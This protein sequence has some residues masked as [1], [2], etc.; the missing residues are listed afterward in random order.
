M[1]PPQHDLSV[2]FD[3]REQPDFPI[4]RRI[5]I[6]HGLYGKARPPMNDWQRR[7]FVAQPFDVR[8]SHSWIGLDPK[9]D[10]KTHPE[11]FAEVDGKRKASKPAYANPEVIQIAIDHALKFFKEHPEAQMISLSPPDGLGFDT[12]ELAKKQAKVVETF[13]AHGTIFGRQKDGTLVSLASENVFHFVNEVAKAV[14]R[15]Y[16]GK[17]VGILAYSAYA[18]PP[19]FDIEPNVYVELTR[20][21]RRTP[22]S[23]VEQIVAFSKKAKN[24]GIYEYYD[25]EQW[26]WERPGRAQRLRPQLPA[27]QLQVL[28]PIQHARP[29]W[30]D[31]QQLRPYGVGYHVLAS[32]LWDATQDVGS[33]RTGVL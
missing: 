19:S 14:Q 32:L 27:R 21:Y 23:S 17:M 25:V 7:N 15:E 16:P 20:G 8:T 24:L 29:Q 18:H 1:I 11:W 6:G 5:W 12:S 28:S 4:Q 3:T 13:P 22:L 2:S 10:F 31:V 9:E 26:A 30:R 33:T